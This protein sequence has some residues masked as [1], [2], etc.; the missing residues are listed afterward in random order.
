MTFQGRVASGTLPG[1]DPGTSEKRDG[2]LPEG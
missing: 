1:V 2:A